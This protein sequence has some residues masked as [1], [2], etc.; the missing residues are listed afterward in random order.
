MKSCKEVVNVWRSFRKRDRQ[1]LRSQGNGH[2]DGNHRVRCLVVL[3][4]VRGSSPTDIAKTLHCSRSQVYRVAERFVED[5]LAGLV[6]R[7]EDNGDEKVTEQYLCA[8]ASTLTKKPIDFGYRRPTWTQELLITVVAQD[9]GVRISRTTMS[10]LLR[11]MDVRL[12]RPKP[13]VL[14]P[15]KKGHRTRRL[16]EIQRLLANLPDGHVAVYVDEV[17]IHLNP[18]IGPDWTLP[19]QPQETVLTPGKNE[20]RYLAGALNAKTGKLTWVE[21]NRKTSELFIDQL[22]TLVLVDYPDA[23]C[24][25][26]VLDNYRIHKSQRTQIALQALEGKVKLH[27]LPPYCPD[28]NKIERVWKDLHDNVTRNHRCRTM[29]QLMNEVREYLKIRKNRGEHGYAKARAR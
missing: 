1:I 6:D 17:D 20:K 9:T 12:R 19:D 8:V 16:R 10:R 7:R 23:K 29:K 13:I 27:F 14:C 5:G 26:I 25:H 21:G 22:W 18:K 4:L 15:W 11:R 2:P 28:H 24:I 3:N